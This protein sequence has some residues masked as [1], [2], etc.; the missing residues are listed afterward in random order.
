MWIYDNWPGE[1]YTG[2]SALCAITIR[3]PPASEKTSDDDEKSQIKIHIFNSWRFNR[4]QKS[5]FEDF[6]QQSGIF[7]WPYLGPGGGCRRRNL[8]ENHIMTL[9]PGVNPRWASRCRPFVNRRRR[10]AMPL[11]SWAPIVMSLCH[12]IIS[13]SSSSSS[14]PSSC[15]CAIASSYL[16]LCYPNIMVNMKTKALQIQWSNLWREDGWQLCEI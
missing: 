11:S 3:L 12:C 8:Q 9:E 15:H 14:S 2:A 13:S 4:N 6:N 1:H 5:T 10:M 16:W 7:K